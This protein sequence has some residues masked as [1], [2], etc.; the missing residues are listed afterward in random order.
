MVELDPKIAENY[1]ALS[2]QIFRGEGES[3]LDPKTR[4][5]IGAVVTTA[6]RND[7]EGIEQYIL[8]A[9]KA[10]ATDREIMAA[11][12]F[13]ALPAGILAAEYAAIVWYE[14]KQGKTAIEF[15]E[16]PKHIVPVSRLRVPRG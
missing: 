3:V 7:R 4:A 5:L 11:I 15:D 13:A 8:R 12:M 10:R 6:V 2:V 16:P 14:M 9:K 1:E